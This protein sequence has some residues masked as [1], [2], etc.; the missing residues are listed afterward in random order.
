M[1]K[2]DRE[3]IDGC[4]Y[5]QQKKYGT[6]DSYDLEGKALI[7]SLTKEHCINATRWHLKFLQEGKFE[8]DKTYS[9]EVSGK[10]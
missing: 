10:L 3:I 5:V 1:T 9:G 8:N 2:E 7:T 6:W 4:F